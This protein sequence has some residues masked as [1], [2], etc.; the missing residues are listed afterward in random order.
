MVLGENNNSTIIEGKAILRERTEDTAKTLKIGQ[1]VA[2]WTGD[3]KYTI[4]RIANTPRRSIS[5]ERVGVGRTNSGQHWLVEVYW[6]D[7]V[8]QAKNKRSMFKFSQSEACSKTNDLC[9]S[10]TGCMKRHADLVYV[11]V[12]LPP[13]DLGMVQ[14]NS[15]TRKRRNRSSGAGAGAGSSLIAPAFWMLPHG[16]KQAI[17]TAISEDAQAGISYVRR[18]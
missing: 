12:V 5:G 3:G 7:E 16:S 15:N 11:D 1:F 10:S 6:G 8:P 17:A 2:L 9:G 14:H 18:T 4:A 13:L